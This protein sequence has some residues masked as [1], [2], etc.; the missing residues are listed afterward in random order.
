MAVA[1]TAVLATVQYAECGSPSW[2]AF[3]HCSCIP[4]FLP[5]YHENHLTLVDLAPAVPLGFHPAFPLSSP[6]ASILMM[7]SACLILYILC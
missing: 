7:D 1:I 5:D 4:A 2:F 3:G 6:E